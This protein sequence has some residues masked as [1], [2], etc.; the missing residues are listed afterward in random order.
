MIPALV[1]AAYLGVVL[2]IGIFASRARHR[3]DVEE[4]FLGR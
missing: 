1:V 3:A 4:Y 2:Y